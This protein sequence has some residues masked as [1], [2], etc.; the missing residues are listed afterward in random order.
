MVQS[1]YTHTHDNYTVGAYSTDLN[2]ETGRRYEAQ[3]LTEWPITIYIQPQIVV[4]YQ[5]NEAFM[6]KI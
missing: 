6:K 4:D 2:P 3:H 5:D 1:N